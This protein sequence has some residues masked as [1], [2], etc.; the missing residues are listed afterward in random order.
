MSSISQPSRCSDGHKSSIRWAA[1][2]PPWNFKSRMILL[3]ISLIFKEFRSLQIHQDN[4]LHLKI[5]WIT[6]PKIAMGPFGTIA[7]KLANSSCLIQQVQQPLKWII[8][9]L[10]NMYTSIQ[11]YHTVT[12]HTSIKIYLCNFIWISSFSKNM[13][14]Q[15]ETNVAAYMTQHKVIF[16]DF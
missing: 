9:L 5:K 8:D 12:L 2:P 3:T 4:I 14:T 7:G 10:C 16:S 11:K 1:V 15:D 6:K 13:T